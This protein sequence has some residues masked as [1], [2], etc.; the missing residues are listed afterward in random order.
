M[1]KYY[2]LTVDFINSEDGKERGQISYRYI[3]KEDILSIVE[4]YIES[5]K[6][7]VQITWSLENI[8]RSVYNMKDFITI[9][10]VPAGEPCVQVGDENY[11][12]TSK[13]ECSAFINQLKREFGNPPP[14]AGLRV[15]AFNHDLGQYREVVCYYEIEDEESKEYCFRLESEVP[16]HWDQI[17]KEEIKSNQ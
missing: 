17:A 14:K 6:F 2:K 1:G 16:E 12:E 7:S 4:M 13:I 3:T 10:P 15:K 11:R 8:T 9:G 5:N